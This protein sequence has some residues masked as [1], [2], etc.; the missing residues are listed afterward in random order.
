MFCGKKSLNQEKKPKRD[1]HGLYRG[2]T[3][4]EQKQTTNKEKE[5]VYGN[6]GMIHSVGGKK[7]RKHWGKKVRRRGKPTQLAEV[8]V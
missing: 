7:G 2:V 1:Q 8:A 4:K 6:T 3:T 5:R